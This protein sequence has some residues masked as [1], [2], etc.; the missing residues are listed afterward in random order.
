[1]REILVLL[2]TFCLI[3]L[4]ESKEFRPRDEVRLKYYKCPSLDD[5]LSCNSKCTLVD[6][7]TSIGLYK[8]IKGHR[9]SGTNEYIMGTFYCDGIACE[10][11]FEYNCQ[12]IS[13]S[14]WACSSNNDGFMSNSSFQNNRYLSYYK[15]PDGKQDVFCAK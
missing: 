12:T 9:L 13:K 1:M 6:K 4:V 8:D 15:S 7:S 2:I 14:H 3:N 5:G 11:V 10:G